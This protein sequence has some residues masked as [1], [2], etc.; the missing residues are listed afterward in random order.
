MKLSGFLVQLSLS[1]R[2]YR[3]DFRQSSRYTIIFYFYKVINFIFIIIIIL[4]P[5]V[6]KKKKKLELCMFFIW[7]NSLRFASIEKSK[8]KHGQPRLL[9]Y[10]SDHFRV[11]MH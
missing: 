10:F 8:L 1:D 4:L 6:K 9:F 3:R 5:I 2:N 11:S 7:Q